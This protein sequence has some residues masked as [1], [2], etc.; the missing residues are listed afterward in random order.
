[1]VNQ[2]VEKGETR[3]ILFFIVSALIILVA[4][5]LQFVNER[6]TDH[7]YNKIIAEK[8]ST[9][10]ASQTV[11]YNSFQMQRSLANLAL[12][13]DSS[14]T[15]LQNKHFFEASDKNDDGLRSI[16]VYLQKAD[17]S[18]KNLFTQVEQANNIYHI[19]C[20][21]F[22]Q[23]LNSIDK[24]AALDFKI[25]KLRSTFDDYTHLQQDMLV[26]L[27]TDALEESKKIS[28]NVNQISLLIFLL[29]IAPY[30]FILGAFLF[31]LLRM[32]RK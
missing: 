5:V 31:F 4:Q 32:L 27:A 15:I 26:K 18:L 9:L 2:K 25:T 21:T 22:L 7:K 1:M 10:L 14:E 29:G 24:Q 16:K 8:D 3:F 12:S 11:L 30:I 17:S 23:M 6:Q 13:E 20:N 28:K 19:N